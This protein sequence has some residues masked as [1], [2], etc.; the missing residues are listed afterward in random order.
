ML[1]LTLAGLGGF[2]L[3][4]RNSMMTVLTRDYMRTARAKGLKKSRVLFRHALRNALPP[5]V[6]R[7]FMSM[8]A[9]FGGSVLVENVFAYPG[10]GLL[11]REAVLAR[12]YVLI[13]GIFLMLAV[14]VLFMNWAAD[15]VY[16]KLDPRVT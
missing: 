8:G 15:L 9:M 12:D 7:I 10:L 2:Y 1:T 13:Q 11:M 6:A 3:L 16:K 4:S 14:S 5:I